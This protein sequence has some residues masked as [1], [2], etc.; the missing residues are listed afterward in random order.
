MQTAFQQD[1]TEFTVPLS[2]PT[3]SDVFENE[4]LNAYIGIIYDKALSFVQMIRH[5]M[6]EERFDQS[7]KEY[8]TE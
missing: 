4:Y 5:A 1:S 6:G 8:L 3:R 7:I 2:D